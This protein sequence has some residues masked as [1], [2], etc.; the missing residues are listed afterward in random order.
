MTT[1]QKQWQLYFLGYYTGEI[2]GDFGPL[3]VAATEAFQRENDV[4]PDGDFGPLTEAKS[5]EVITA[6]QE[7]VGAEPDGL[8]G[9]KT[10]AATITYQKAHG[11]SPDGIAGPLTRAEIAKDADVNWEEVKYF[12]RDEFKCKCKGKHCDGFPVEPSKVLVTVCD[13]TREHFGCVMKVNSGVRCQD[14]NDSLDGSVPN[15][16]HILGKAVD[17]KIRTEKGG[18]LGA[19]KILEYVKQQPEIRYAYAINSRSV[20]MDVK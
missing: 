10:I 4:E 13:R 5:I 16:R 2:D 19:K 6:I 18:Y 17:F 12:D 1:K 11:L 20:H 14:Y 7:A 3:S 8:A 9:P 15:S